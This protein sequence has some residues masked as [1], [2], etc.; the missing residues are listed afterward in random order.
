MSLL[1]KIPMSPK[2]VA[3]AAGDQ[4]VDLAMDRSS[5]PPAKAPGYG[6]LSLAFDCMGDAEG[7]V[8]V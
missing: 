7:T 4:H 6:P 8:R 2:I 1:G 3:R 5:R